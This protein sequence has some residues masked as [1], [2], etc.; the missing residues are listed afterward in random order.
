MEVSGL[1]QTLFL[2]LNERDMGK[3][4]CPTT[5]ENIL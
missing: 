1:A 3:L 5:I 2:P 4:L